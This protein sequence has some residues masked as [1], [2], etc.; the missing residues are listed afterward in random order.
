MFLFYLLG[1]WIGLGFI[2]G[3]W[4]HLEWIRA[5][6]RTDGSIYPFS[7]CIGF[8]VVGFFVLEQEKL[9]SIIGWRGLLI[10]TIET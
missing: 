2:C 10:H 5:D 9:S 7:F 8:G 4:K 6:G 3:V 1:G